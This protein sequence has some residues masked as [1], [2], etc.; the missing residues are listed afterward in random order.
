MKILDGHSKEIIMHKFFYSLQ[1]S[2]SLVWFQ[3]LQMVES[4]LL[5]IQT[6][7]GGISWH[8]VCR[9]AYTPSARKFPRLSSESGVVQTSKLLVSACITYIR[10]VPIPMYVFEVGAK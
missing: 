9:L 6:R 8:L 4:G 10:A 1:M 2:V 7:D 3:A 5:L